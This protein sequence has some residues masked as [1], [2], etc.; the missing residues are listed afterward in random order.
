MN[1][2]ESSNAISIMVPDSR[3]VCQPLLNHCRMPFPTPEITGDT[4]GEIM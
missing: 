1:N 3:D 4:G 2:V